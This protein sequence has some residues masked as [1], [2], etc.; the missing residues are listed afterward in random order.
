MTAKD[1]MWIEIT[2]VSRCSV[3][4]TKAY[5]YKYKTRNPMKNAA[6]KRFGILRGLDFYVVSKANDR[7]PGYY[8]M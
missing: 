3:Y 6:G 2:G 1:W 5:D 7:L 8:K 4:V